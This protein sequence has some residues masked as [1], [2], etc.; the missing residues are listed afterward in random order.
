MAQTQKSANIIIN[1]YEK[2]VNVFISSFKNFKINKSAKERL[3]NLCNKHN[4]DPN[5]GE[6]SYRP[7][8]KSDGKNDVIWTVT[9]YVYLKRIPKDLID[10]WKTSLILEYIPRPGRCLDRHKSN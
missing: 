10:G 8:N 4:L 5:N 3:I 6:I 1:D 7:I 9:H 2:S